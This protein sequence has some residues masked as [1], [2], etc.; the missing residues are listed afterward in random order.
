MSLVKAAKEAPAAAASQP[1]ASPAPAAPAAPTLAPNAGANEGRQHLSPP[2]VERPEYVPEKFWKDGKLDTETALKSYSELEA[3]LRTKTEDL[4]AQLKSEARQGLPE[5]PDKYELKI[6]DAPVPVEELAQHPAMQWW[7]QAAFDA[8]IAPDKFNEGVGQ[9][10]GIL[11]AGPDLEAEKKALGENADV[12]IG[13]VSTWA[14]TTFTD[15]DE[16]KAV[17]LLGTSAAGIKVLEK[18]MGTRA[19][20]APDAP[21]AAPGMTIE[22]LRTMQ[23]DPRYF[24]PGRRDPAW[25]KQ[26]DEGFE[27]LYGAKK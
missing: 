10:V 7:R 15:P 25:V 20:T 17:Q 1:P 18:L 8:G 19:P 23:A 12:R 6:E 27:A 9:L 21:A 16:F 13:A 2:V 14:R 4:M 24:D 22:K 5:S 26:V 3:K 11:T